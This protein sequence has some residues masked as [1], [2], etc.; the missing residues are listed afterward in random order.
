[1]ATKN[2]SIPVIEEKWL[3]FNKFD[4]STFRPIHFSWP[5][6]SGTKTVVIYDKCTAQKKDVL[7]VNVRNY[8][9]SNYFVLDKKNKRIFA[10]PLVLVGNDTRKGC[11]TAHWER[12]N[13]YYDTFIMIDENKQIWEIP[14]KGTKTIRT[15][16]PQMRRYD[17][18]EE[19]TQPTKKSRFSTMHYR[20]SC[21]L[22]SHI[23]EMFSYLFGDELIY[24]THV[25]TDE[26]ING[27][28]WYWT[29]WL[30][31]KGRKLSDKTMNKTRQLM[32]LLGER[33]N[34]PKYVSNEKG[35]YYHKKVNVELNAANGMKFLSYFDEGVECFRRVYN[36]KT[37]KFEGYVWKN[38]E[39]VKSQSFNS[40]QSID[41]FVVDDTFVK[42]FPYDSN[43][44]EEAKQFYG[45]NNSNPDSNMHSFAANYVKLAALSQI[46]QIQGS[47]A[48]KEMY[49]V[50]GDLERAYG[51]MPNKGKTLYRKL[52]IN[53]YQMNNP[54]L[55]AHIKEV[56]KTNDI[57]FIDNDTWDMCLQSISNSD[58]NYGWRN[59][60]ILDFLRS[61]DKLTL[62]TWAKINKLNTVRNAEVRGH[63]TGWYSGKDET[64][65][66][67]ADYYK[68]LAAMKEFGM[69]ISSYPLTFNEFSQLRRFHDDAAHAVSAVKNRAA[70]EKFEM[71][72]AQR[73]KMLEDDGEF[74]IDMPQC[75]ADLTNE[76]SY[77]HHC[78][79]GY[80]NSVANGST[81]IYFLRKKSEPKTPWLTVE[82]ANKSCRQIHGACNAWMGSKDEYFAAVPFLVYWFNKHNIDFAENL[83]T[84]K[85][86]GYG[87]I[88]DRRNMPNEE[89]KAYA[90]K[91]K[92][93]K[94]VKA[95]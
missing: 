30:G 15:W 11:E 22:V 94:K 8:V 82:V 89:I 62:Q 38:N 66:L 25:I 59:R 10:Y 87:S 39:W 14:T 32:E 18:R 36:T 86:T 53:K 45:T 21:Q 41:Q 70:D 57:A 73:E 35:T 6:A 50:H 13:S 58:N 92:Q 90:E 16:N 48:R 76:G 72:Y 85:A 84:N 46:L 49:K 60:E 20:T 68:S 5:L 69:N 31:T 28:H 91:R 26:C 55:I 83:L 17:L 71:L 52:G 9:T 95:S 79:G 67:Y 81:A 29:Y 12:V 2:N 47:A 37:K 1:M 77:L 64:K 56:L 78:V 24:Q 19:P 34:N 33:K 65:Q 42:A 54:R 51:K 80:V 43:I 7:N 61:Q 63:N 3:N 4:E 40:Y 44:L 88:S 23:R 93:A 27:V 74:I 75:S